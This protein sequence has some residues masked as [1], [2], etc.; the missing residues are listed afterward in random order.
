MAMFP[1]PHATSR[2]FSLD[3]TSRFS[4]WRSPMN[5]ETEAMRAKSP[6]PHTCFWTCVTVWRSGWLMRATLP[7]VAHRQRE[8]VGH[9]VG[10]QALRRAGRQRHAHPVDVAARVGV[11][12]RRAR[13]VDRERLAGGRVD[14]QDR[15]DV[16]LRWVRAGEVGDHLVAAAGD[17]TD[18]DAVRLAVRGPAL[19]VAVG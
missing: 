12:L 17:R 5:C 9:H 18:R 6:A 19:V 2:T 10:L 15:D 16:L 14:E 11:G 3:I 7:E 8:D 13:V 4:T 1:L